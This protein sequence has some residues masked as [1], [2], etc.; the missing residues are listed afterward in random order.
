MEWCTSRSGR[1]ISRIF[2][3]LLPQPFGDGSRLTG[4]HTSNLEMRIEVDFQF[5]YQVDYG[6]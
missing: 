3:A 5:Y 6:N 4:L 1:E 2:E